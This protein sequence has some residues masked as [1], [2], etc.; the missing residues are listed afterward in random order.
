MSSRARVLLRGSP[1]GMI[2]PTRVAACCV[3]HSV[4]DEC[5]DVTRPRTAALALQV[6]KTSLDREPAKN[7]LETGWNLKTIASQE[8]F[9]LTPFYY[10]RQ[11][12]PIHFPNSTELARIRIERYG[13][14]YQ[15]K[16]HAPDGNG[17]PLTLRFR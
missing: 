6:L 7:I 14:E 1:S 13:D 4:T 5:Y 12:Q 10:F 2:W 3:L 15:L 17:Q 9:F 8:K 11:P 16:P